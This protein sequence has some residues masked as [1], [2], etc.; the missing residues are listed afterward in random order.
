M[1]MISIDQRK[2]IWT[3]NY[4]AQL[5]KTKRYLIVSIW[6]TNQKRQ[7]LWWC[8]S[9]FTRWCNDAFVQRAACPLRFVRS[10]A[11]RDW[12]GNQAQWIY[13]EKRDQGSDNVGERDRSHETGC[14]AAMY[15]CNR[16]CLPWE[17]QVPAPMSFQTWEQSSL[18]RYITAFPPFLDESE[19]CR[20][21]QRSGEIAR[22]LWTWYNDSGRNMMML[23]LITLRSTMRW[24]KGWQ[25]C[26]KNK[27]N[28]C[29]AHP[30]PIK[31]ANPW[32]N[33]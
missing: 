17:W 13:R 7:C 4:K 24:R 18:H 23:L 22:A 6:L 8:Y 28:N 2:Q 33:K 25:A 27:S 11:N 32:T 16:K 29:N 26:S 14:A 19:N 20:S 1:N 9:L 31:Y 30:S 3:A 12:H 5:F 15:R 10:I 21:S